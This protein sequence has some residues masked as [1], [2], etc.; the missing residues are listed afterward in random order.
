MLVNS[1]YKM[2]NN[3]TC[4]HMPVRMQVSSWPGFVS[5]SK[6]HC[7]NKN[8]FMTPWNVQCPDNLDHNRAF[9]LNT[10]DSHQWISALQ[11]SPP[12]RNFITHNIPLSHMLILL[13][14]WLQSNKLNAGK[15]YCPMT[16]SIF[17]Y[18][19]K[20]FFFKYRFCLL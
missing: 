11:T 13:L 18:F 10:W 3:F 4:S 6:A 19:C 20:D 16:I 12:A 7:I 8:G 2:M 5:A 14:F 1:S 17:I 9:T 15:V